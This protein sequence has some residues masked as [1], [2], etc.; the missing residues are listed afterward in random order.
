[1]TLF[2]AWRYKSVPLAFALLANPGPFMKLPRQFFKP[3]A[4]GAPAPMRDLPVRLERMIHFVPPHLEKLRQKVP[5]LIRQVD[6][7][8]GN[9]EDAIPVDAKEAARRGFIEMGKAY[10]YGT[11]GLWTRI[12]A[13]NSP[14]VLDDV[15]DIVATIG[16]KLDVI[17]LPKVEGAWDIHYLDQLLAQLEA[18]HHISRPILIH[19]ILETAEG[20]NNV[21]TIASASPRM[22]G[23]SLG[24]ADLAASRAMK[25]TRV[26]GGHPDYVVLADSNAGDAPGSSVR[27]A[28]QQDLWHYT[29]AR[30]VD[31]CAAA[32][33]KAFY[34]PFGD[35]ADPAACEAQFRNSFLMGCAGA[36][37]LHPTQIEIAKRVFSPDPAEVGFAKK[38]LAAMPDGSGAVMIDGKMQD[39]ATWKQAR[40]VV[41]LARMVAAKDPAMA[42]LYGL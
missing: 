33:I 38:I 29:I 28:F 15:I 31:A 16:N 27:A 17:M 22:H 34:G 39:D 10:D 32:G 9:L 12:N 23:I 40:V 1:V 42:A 20:V 41:D 2:A 5:D 4:I 36:W 37:S 30:M 25:T 19:A 8:L 3:L 24:P 26:G 11:T 6:V 21:E 18:R 13:L 7:V 35:F 14:W